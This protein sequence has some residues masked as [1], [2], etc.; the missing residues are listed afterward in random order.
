[1]KTFVSCHLFIIVLPCYVSF[2]LS[3]LKISHVFQQFDN[4]VHRCD[5]LCICLFFFFAVCF[6]A[7]LVFFNQ[8]WKFFNFYF[9]TFF[10][11]GCSPSPTG[12]KLYRL[13]HLL[14]IPYVKSVHFFNPFNLS[15]LQFG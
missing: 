6:C 12:F 14:F 7:L 8:T 4:Y 9:F 1:M 10:C 3:A 5:F 11:L 2:F 15:M 13:D